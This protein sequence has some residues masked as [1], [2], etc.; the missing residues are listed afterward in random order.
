MDLDKKKKN[1]GT[2]VPCEVLEFHLNFFKE[3]E[4]HELKYFT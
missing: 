1:S 3:L 2:Q 4:F